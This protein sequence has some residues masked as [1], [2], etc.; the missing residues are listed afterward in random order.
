MTKVP[1]SVS[2]ASPWH[3]PCSSF[4][5]QC[6]SHIP[7]RLFEVCPLRH[8][9]RRSLPAR[10]S[11]GIRAAPARI[12]AAT[13]LSASKTASGS[14]ETTTKQDSGTKTPRPRSVKPDRK[15]NQSKSATSAK[16][17]NTSSRAVI[18]QQLLRIETE[19]AYAALVAGSPSADAQEDASRDS[20]QITYSVSNIL[21]W[22]RRLD[23]TIAHL[24]GKPCTKLEHRVHAILRLAVHELLFQ[25]LPAHAVSEHVNLAKSLVRPAAGSLVNA[26]LRRLLR[27]QEQG[28]LPEPP[29][30]DGSTPQGKAAEML[31]VATSHPTWMVARWLQR[32]G[33]QEAMSLLAHNNRSTP[34]YAVRVCP[35]LDLSP[36]KLV[37][38]LQEAGVEA[39]VSS[40][41]PKDFLVAT[42]LQH[43]IRQGFLQRGSCQVQDEA[44]GLVVALLDPQPGE[45]ILDACAAPGGKALYAAARMQNQGRLVAMD[46]HKKRLGA[47]KT[48]AAAQGLQE[49][50]TTRTGDL[51]QYAD[52]VA[53]QPEDARQEHQY[54]RVLVDAP[55]SGL[56]VL[57]KRV[58]LRWRRTPEE[59]TELATLQAQLLDAAATLVKPS[60]LLVYSTCSIEPEENTDQVAAFLARNSDYAHEAASEDQLPGQ[61][62]SAGG[63][64]QTLPHVHDMDGAFGARLRRAS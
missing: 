17:S 23:F 2:C 29:M 16:K 33:Q 26:V 6:R 34:A 7:V 22:Q 56:G 27:E 37:E 13:S 38:Q 52:W 51:C 49:L 57:A 41:L 24:T 42:G 39:A 10:S 36:Q 30:P 43:L 54:D 60:G 1:S 45:T 47:L 61:V 53:A 15:S 31:A 9:L 25:E 50:I 4:G 28:T 3:A 46:I 64:L 21:R 58:D 12:A 8:A 55:C 62:I 19:G 20:R 63:F 59:L 32:W 44:A 40:V 5:R 11:S 35:S 48:A 18:V 14:P